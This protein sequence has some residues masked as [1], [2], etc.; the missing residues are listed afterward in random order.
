MRFSC[1]WALG[2][3]NNTISSMQP[4]VGGVDLRANSVPLTVH[5]VGDVQLG[6]LTGKAFGRIRAG[7]GSLEEDQQRKR[8]VP[9]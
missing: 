5:P 2:K 6:S 7:R 9:A 8:G 4:G 1:K 3:S